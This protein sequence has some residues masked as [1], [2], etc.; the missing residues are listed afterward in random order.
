M[1]E[2]LTCFVSTNIMLH[3]AISKECF[4]DLATQGRPNA[5]RTGTTEHTLQ[6][7]LPT[8]LSPKLSSCQEARGAGMLSL[9]HLC[10]FSHLL[11]P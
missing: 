10:N 1:S 4:V 9:L 8:H 3:K 6:P 2:K 5:G 11:K 7:C